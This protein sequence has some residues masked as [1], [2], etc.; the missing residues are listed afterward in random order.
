MCFSLSLM[1]SR[2]GKVHPDR[3]SGNTRKVKTD[4][5]ERSSEDTTTLLESFSYVLRIYKCVPHKKF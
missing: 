1:Y 2:G 5:I 4:G 3:V